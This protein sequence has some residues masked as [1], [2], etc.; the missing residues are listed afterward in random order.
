MPSKSKHCRHLT[1][2]PRSRATRPASK[3]PSSTPRSRMILSRETSL[4][5]TRRRM[6]SIR[7]TSNLNR[8]FIVVYVVTMVRPCS[9]R[10]ARNLVSCTTGSSADMAISRSFDTIMSLSCSR[11]A[12]YISF[13]FLKYVYIV[14]LPLSEA[15]AISFIVVFSKPLWTKS[16]RATS[17]SFS[18]VFNTIAQYL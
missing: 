11:T 9:S 2:K 5:W 12:L 15:L 1:T 17:I 3:L 16:C 4:S 18:R 10:R 8:F 6:R 13:L 14:R 7:L